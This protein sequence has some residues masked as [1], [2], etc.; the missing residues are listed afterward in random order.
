MVCSL[1]IALYAPQ[2]RSVYL[3]HAQAQLLLH[4]ACRYGYMNRTKGVPCPQHSLQI[5]D[6]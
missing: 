6:P 3:L 4:G 2:M 5:G 1:F